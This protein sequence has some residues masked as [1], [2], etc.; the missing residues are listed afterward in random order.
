VSASTAGVS[1]EGS[2]MID[3]KLAF[4]EM[5]GLTVRADGGHIGES[6]EQTVD[7][8]ELERIRGEY[9]LRPLRG[10][11]DD[12]SHLGGDLF[13]EIFTGDVGRLYER[14]RGSASV[15]GT[16]VR[17]SLG[18]GPRSTL[19]GIPWELFHDGA[20]FLAKRSDVFVVRAFELIDP[21]LRMEVARPLRVLFTA[22]TP[23]DLPRLDLRSE[24]E[25]VRRAYQSL[26]V[27]AAITGE[28]HLTRVRLEH[29]FLNA[30]S[31]ATPFHVWHHC[32]HG[33][34]TAARDRF[35]LCLERGG[36]TERIAIGEA[37]DLVGACPGLRL[38]ILNC[39][40]GGT[41]AGLAPELARLNVPVA[42]GFPRAVADSTAVRFAG[43][44]HSN[45][46]RLPVEEAVG[47]ARRFMSPGTQEWTLPLLLS[48]RRDQGPL[49][50]ARV[51]DQLPGRAARGAPGTIIETNRSKNGAVIGEN[52]GDIHIDMAPQSA[53]IDHE[54]PKT[55]SR[56]PPPDA[57]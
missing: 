50:T 52:K 18:F 29:L 21:H 8:A 9:E 30:R 39:C 23:S 25:N 13:R 14:A 17:V 31:A 24:E 47:V 37:A 7:R 36:G 11:D 42:I 53:T 43:A 28:P 45:L 40:H 10:A 32:G 57:A 6:G 1:A 54:N 15:N 27:A 3:L 16:S 26:G 20:E 19:H 12:L 2:R 44:L 51:G 34:T 38:V 49:L 4:H 41:L 22:A 48:R 46:T 55:R 33:G 56:K 35:W 5:G